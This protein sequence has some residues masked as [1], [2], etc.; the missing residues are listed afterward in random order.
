MA[1][2]KLQSAKKKKMII[3]RNKPREKFKDKFIKKT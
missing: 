2:K 3:F 1:G